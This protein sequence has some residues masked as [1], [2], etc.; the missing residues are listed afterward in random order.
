[1]N[2]TTAQAGFKLALML[3]TLLLTACASQPRTQFDA[4]S[5]APK[6]VPKLSQAA[7]QQKPSVPYLERAKLNSEQWQ[8]RL[9]D[10]SA[11]DSDAKPSTTP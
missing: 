2:K 4:P 1:M 7:R 5:V 10:T 6:A 11:L 8:K 9:N 3:Q